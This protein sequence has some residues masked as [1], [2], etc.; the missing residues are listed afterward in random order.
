MRTGKQNS[1]DDF[2]QGIVCP[3]TTQ[4]L[5]D[6]GYLVPARTFAA[7]EDYSDI[8]MKGSDFDNG[9][10]F[11]KFNQTKLYDGVV[12]N[13]LKFANGLKAICFNVNVE[14]SKN[15]CQ[16]FR[17]NGIRAEHIDGNTPDRERE[18]I[19]KAFETENFVLCNCSILTTG[20]DEPSIKCVIINRA[21]MSLPLFLQMAGRGSRI[22]EGKDNFI[23]ID[24]GANVYRHGMWEEDREW[25]LQKK[26][27]KKKS[28]GVA[29]VKVCDSCH[30]I[31]HNS[32]RKCKVCDAPFEIKE[33][34]LAKSEFVEVKKNR[35]ARKI[36]D[37]KTASRQELS[38]Y[39]KL[40]GYK[41]G[42]VFKQLQIAGRM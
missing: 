31:N 7:K 2:Y 9:A 33:K 11:N 21:T 15:M 27:K 32:A 3:V 29:P 38:E 37:I 41:Q 23:I 10:L 28:D 14:H 20:F 39:A 13:Y 1:L 36:P 30:A 8:K 35:G 19:L 18:R 24:Q 26:V 17:E 12:E 6:L 4:Q 22:F 40:M 5:I 34:K 25:S 42:W 16:K